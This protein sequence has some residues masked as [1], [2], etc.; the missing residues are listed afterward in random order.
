MSLIIQFTLDY[1]PKCIN[2][3]CLVV[4]IKCNDEM[5][6]DALIAFH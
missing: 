4:G 5:K 6:F 2:N 1:T 3:E